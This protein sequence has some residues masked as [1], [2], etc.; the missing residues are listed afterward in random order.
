MSV[1]VLSGQNW[2]HVYFN[3]VWYMQRHI[4]LY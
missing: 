2:I 1:E 4:Y 3:E